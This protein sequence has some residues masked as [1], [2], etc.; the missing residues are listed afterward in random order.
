MLF[1]FLQSFSYVAFF[2]KGPV[3]V[4]FVVVVFNLS[5]TSS[6]GKRSVFGYLSMCSELQKYSSVMKLTEILLLASFSS[7]F[8]FLKN[9]DYQVLE[10]GNQSIFQFFLLAFLFNKSSVEEIRE[11]VHNHSD[12]FSQESVERKRK[13]ASWLNA[14]DISNW[15]LS[16]LKFPA[17]GQ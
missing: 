12:T 13:E 8:S 4:F 3:L 9:S 6:Y 11:K 2:K 5:W 1:S 15:F 14:S 10:K 17:Q 16:I 7:N